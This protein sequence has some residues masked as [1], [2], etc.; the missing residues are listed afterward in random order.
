MRTGKSQRLFFLW[1][2]LFSIFLL[3][4]FVRADAQDASMCGQAPRID[5]ENVKGQLDGK[6]KFLASFIGD[7]Q[8]AG[9]IEIARNDVFSKSPEGL[10]ARSIAYLQY[11]VCILLFTNKDLSTSQKIDELLKVQASFGGKN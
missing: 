6:A 11:Q 5:D 4:P 1:L 10:K 3:N 2:A 9:Q 8:L 7:A